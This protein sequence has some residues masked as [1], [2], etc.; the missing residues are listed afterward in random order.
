MEQMLFE[1]NFSKTKIAKSLVEAE[2]SNGGTVATDIAGI[3]QKSGFS[4]ATLS[5]TLPAL[6]GYVQPLNSPV[7]YIFGFRPKGLSG[8]TPIEVQTLS[9]EPDGTTV[10]NPISHNT[11]EDF[12]ITRK[13]VSTGL[14][15]VKIDMTP[16]VEQDVLAL[17][18]GHFEEDYHTFLDPSTSGKLDRV[19][20]IFFEYSSTQMVKKT[21]KSFTDYLG[22]VASPLGSA[23]ITAADA[24]GQLSI[25]LGKMQSSLMSKRNKM[26][27]RFWIICSA[28]IAAMLSTM[29]DIYY[30]ESK[31]DREPTPTENT[32][33]TTMG[34]MDVFMS[35]DVAEGTIYMGI[36]GN[37]NTSSIYYNPYNEYMINGGADPYSGVSN[38]FFRARDAWSTN[39]VDSFGGT[40]P[41]TGSNTDVIESTASDFVVKAVVTLPVLLA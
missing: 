16:S 36:L 27:G 9:T 12:I 28:E 23:T 40:Q 14:R 41:A 7:G 10:T 5:R 1:N 13:T 32:F 15:E 35:P 11:A 33:V 19:A 6:V 8:S 25:I 20:S 31:S 39:P 18:G 2:P 22:T 26:A 4:K 29:G 3:E 34:N 37:A 24:T 30:G 38:V 17:F 21:N